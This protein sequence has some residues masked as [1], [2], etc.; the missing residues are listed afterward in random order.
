MKKTFSFQPSVLCPA[1]GHSSPEL[2]EQ[3]IEAFEKG[4]YKASLEYLLDSV[5]PR[6]RQ[7]K[8]G[9]KTGE[10][11]IS[12]G[13][14]R[15]QIR[16]HQGKLSVSA[17]LVTLSSESSVAM[18]RQVAALNFNDLDL[19]RLVLEE[20]GLYFRFSCPLHFGHPQKIRGVLEEICHV[21]EKYDY[22]F[23]NEFKVDRLTEPDFNS[24]SSG[25]VR[26]IY[27]TMQQSCR[28]C[29]EAIRYFRSL[30][31]FSEEWLLLR[32]T[33]LKLIYVA[34]PKGR[35]LRTL[36][37][38]VKDMDRDL[39]LTELIADGKEVLEKI[40]GKSMEEI[41]DSLYYTET[42]IPCK[43]RSTFQE[44]RENYESCY[45]QVAAL[46]ECGDYR[47]VCLKII[48]KIYETYHLY[49]VDDQMDLLF[50]KALNDTSCQSWAIAAPVLYQLIDNIMQGRI[51]KEI[52]SA[53]A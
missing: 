47:K 22:E 52:P 23:L 20:D 8:S 18:L 39:P 44:L 49:E 35:L 50:V 3:S 40:Q 27:E 48:H 25:Q 10:Y 51:K 26:N 16:Q 53:A 19:T 6:I 41:S 42:F 13:P 36:Q 46:M 24:Y 9:R 43:K 31:Q 14:L 2:F 37:K 33:F 11:N 45:K 38:A 30:R 1:I 34:Q 12:H 17:P 28:D 29:L 21:G 15:I 4:K 5:D 7:K 32:T